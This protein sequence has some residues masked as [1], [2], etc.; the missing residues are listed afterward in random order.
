MQIYESINN[1]HSSNFRSQGFHVSAD[2]DSQSKPNLLTKARMPPIQ[3]LSVEVR[4]DV[5][6]PF[7]VCS[8]HSS[9]VDTMARD[10]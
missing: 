8:F 9:A 2:G 6:L 10:E 7:P 3:T 4:S 5:R 1:N